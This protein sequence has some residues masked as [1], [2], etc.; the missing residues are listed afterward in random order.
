MT[1]RDEHNQGSFDDTLSFPEWAQA[2]RGS[3]RGRDEAER[4]LNEALQQAGRDSASPRMPDL[5]SSILSA[6]ASKG[7]F[8]DERVRTKRRYT[9]AVVLGLLVGLSACVAA[10][11]IDR[12]WSASKPGA[13]ERVVASAARDA[14][15]SIS[16]VRSLSSL[17]SKG[18]VET[19][20][21]DAVEN[22]AGA[23][24]GG[25][26]AVAPNLRAVAAQVLSP[27]TR[28]EPSASSAGESVLAAAMPVGSF[29]PGPVTPPTLSSAER[30]MTEPLNQAAK[31]GQA[32]R[33]AV[34]NVSGA[35]ASPAT[36]SVPDV[37][38]LSGLPMPMQAPQ[39]SADPLAVPF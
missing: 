9:R 38:G 5:S 19:I 29:L 25:L 36:K 12:P 4:D 6:V 23:T 31:F 22:D 2:P 39:Q 8:V 14:R 1:R 11:L 26:S 30:A 34:V 13:L 17:L 3:R 27:I 18:G 10:V 37:G 24:G 35:G 16:Q 7:V 15:G 21:N 20:E 32:L 28:A 33:S